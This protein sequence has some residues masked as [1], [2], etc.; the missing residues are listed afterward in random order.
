MREK[1]IESKIKSKSECVCV[2]MLEREN[3]MDVDEKTNP[4][5]KVN[6]LKHFFPD[7]SAT[8]LHPK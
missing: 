1:E 8:I 7:I 4:S 2:W 6:D 3:D 5:I